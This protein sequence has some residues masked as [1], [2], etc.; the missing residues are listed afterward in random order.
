MTR[1]L[2]RATRIGVATAT[3]ACAGLALASAAS[4][5]PFTQDNYIDVP[6]CAQP[7]TQL[8]AQIPSASVGAVMAPSVSFTAN[9]NH[10]SDI[11]AHVIVD[12][13]EVGADQVGPG[14]S[15]PEYPLTS[16][17]SHTVGVQAEGVDGGCNVGYLSAWGGTLHFKG[18]SPLS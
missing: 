3:L 1:T 10:C 15:T 5:K 18:T 8:C 2:S 14:Q 11:I 12:G 17:R 4:A 6:D 16:F 13:Q 9:A 7:Q